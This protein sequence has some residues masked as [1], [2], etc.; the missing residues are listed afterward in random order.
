MKRR[1]RSLKMKFSVF[2]K[3]KRETDAEVN[4]LCS[5]YGIW[6]LRDEMVGES[7][8]TLAKLLAQGKDVE[9]M[10]PSTIRSVI[11]RTAI[12]FLR[13]WLGK[14]GHKNSLYLEEMFVDGRGKPVWEEK[15]RNGKTPEEK[16]LSGEL[17]EELRKAL[18]RLTDKERLVIEK[19][20]L[21]EKEGKEVAAIM[22]L[23]PSSVSVYKKKA[24]AKLKNLLP[25]NQ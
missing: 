25:E 6:H 17:E 5:L 9:K 8:L 23:S 15:I 13:S 19:I 1:R 21:D 4:R 7:Y 22:G 16:F 20:Y 2:E 3:W 12:D 10:K 24:L 11:R 18:T 14:K